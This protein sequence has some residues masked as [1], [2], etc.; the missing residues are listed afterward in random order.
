VVFEE[1]VFRFLLGPNNFVPRGAGWPIGVCVVSG[2]G[3]QVGSFVT[4]FFARK[5]AVKAFTLG[6]V[7][8]SAGL[9]LAVHALAKDQVQAMWW[10]AAS[11]ALSA[12]AAV[13]A[14]WWTI[15]IFERTDARAPLAGEVSGVSGA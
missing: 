13:M 3:F 1:R 11:M 15:R 12:T 7:V 14:M 5:A 6:A 4:G 9:G 8:I 10:Y 2:V